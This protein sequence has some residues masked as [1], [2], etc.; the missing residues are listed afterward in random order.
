MAQTDVR[1]STALPLTRRSHVRLIFQARSSTTIMDNMADI[2][3]VLLTTDSPPHCA[4][5]SVLHTT[6]PPPACWR[7]RGGSFT[8]SRVFCCYSCCWFPLPPPTPRLLPDPGSFHFPACFHLFYP[9][10]LLSPPPYPPLVAVSVGVLCCRRLPRFHNCP[11]ISSLNSAQLFRSIHPD[12]TA[13]S[14]LLPPTGVAAF[15][16]QPFTMTINSY[17]YNFSPSKPQPA[18]WTAWCCSHTIENMI[19]FSFNI[20]LQWLLPS[21]VRTFF[22]LPHLI[23][24]FIFPSKS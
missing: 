5:A 2:L 20:S 23:F 18:Y 15:Y 8:T 11:S 7:R 6:T 21:C 16:L 22:W 17:F 19:N 1:T 10:L 3:I 12:P 14:S 24:L 13:T 4:V 9:L